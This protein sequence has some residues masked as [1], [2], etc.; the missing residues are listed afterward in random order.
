MI[1]RIRRMNVKKMLS[2][3]VLSAVALSMTTLSAN[4][5]DDAQKKEI[6]AIVKDYLLQI[7]K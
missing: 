3:T 2:A 6:G 1:T 7:P 5:F 4:A